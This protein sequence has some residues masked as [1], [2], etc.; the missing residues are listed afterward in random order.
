M[1]PVRRDLVVLTADKDALLGIKT[2]L[3]RFDVL[4]IRPITFDCFAHSK[5]DA[6]VFIGAHT[7][8]RPFSQ[9]FDHALAVFD[10]EGCGQ[11]AR[12]RDAV[13]ARVHEN[14]VAN[15]WENRCAA[16]AL[17]PELESWIWDRSLYVSRILKWDK[18]QLKNWL[19][20]EQF[21]PSAD[22]VKPVRPKEAFR[23][24]M[25]AA[26]QPLSSS[27]FQDLAQFSKI[28]G[29]SDP[30]FLK[31]VSTLHSW[32]PHSASRQQ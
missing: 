21:L 22:S 17:N 13:E 14:L 8:L 23:G 18:A 27:L 1:T 30:S 25:R 3:S 9:Y 6:G 26:R 31:F 2:L 4:G 11:E 24:A 32:F 15:G 7:F 10:L 16:V 20:Q 28:A 12:G 5:H 19:L 29:C